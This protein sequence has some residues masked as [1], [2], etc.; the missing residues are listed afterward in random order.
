MPATS[1]PHVTVDLG[2]HGTWTA[3]TPV[4][5][6]A[7][8]RYLPASPQVLRSLVEERLS[9]NNL[10]GYQYARRDWSDIASVS[11]LLVVLAA[12]D[13]NVVKVP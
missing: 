13:S 12:L 4:L 7:I 8:N 3:S 1:S 2:P 11:E 10:T 5:D 6:R 9:T